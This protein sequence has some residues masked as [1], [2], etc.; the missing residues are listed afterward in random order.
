MARRPGVV[1]VDEVAPAGTALDWRDG[2]NAAVAWV[3]LAADDPAGLR[4]RLADLAG[5]LGDAY[6][7]VDRRGR[8]VRDQ[9]WLDR[10][11]ERS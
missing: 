10:I 9:D 8:P 4:A 6:G 3:W 7:F 2:T 5:W 1:A 11:T